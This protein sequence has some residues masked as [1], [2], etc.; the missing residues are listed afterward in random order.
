MLLA[1]LAL[2]VVLASA[3]SLYAGHLHI[4]ESPLEIM[5][6]FGKKC[7]LFSFRY[8]FGAHRFGAVVLFFIA[9][10]NR[11][12]PRLPAVV[13]LTSLVNDLLRRIVLLRLELGFD[14]Q[15]HYIASAS[16]PADTLSRLVNLPSSPQEPLP[17]SI[18]SLF[19]YVIDSTPTLSPAHIPSPDA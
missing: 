19:G 8:P 3:G 4:V 18:S 6:S 5:I 10:T 7:S 9:T 17:T 11:V 13:L 12:L 2:A 1:A 16:N 14:I 15:I